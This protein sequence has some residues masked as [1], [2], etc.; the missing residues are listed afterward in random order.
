MTG[1]AGDGNLT[2]EG[3]LQ[4]INAVFGL[5]LILS[6]A[7]TPA[8]AM[9]LVTTALRGFAPGHTAVAWHPN[10]SGDY[11][12]QAPGDLGPAL[13][14][15][16][17]PGQVDGDGAAR[18]AFPLTA[19]LGREPVFLGPPAPGAPLAPSE[20]RR[21]AVLAAALDAVVVI[22]QEARVTYVNGAFEQTFGYRAG[23]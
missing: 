17:A 7:A 15:L 11:Y 9:R 20:A 2:A 13:A 21:G 6:Q 16:T 19:A 1:P 8:G 4:E 3:H 12:Q 5:L 22:D 18:W 14:R 23:E 10:R